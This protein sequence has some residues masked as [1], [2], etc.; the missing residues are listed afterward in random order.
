MNDLIVVD[1]AGVRGRIHAAEL[2]HGGPAVFPVAL[3]TGEHV[4]IPAS[5]LKQ[6]GANL[7][8]FP[9][10]FSDLIREQHSR[11]GDPQETIIP[12]VEEVLEVQRRHVERGVRVTKT[13]EE[14]T[15]VIDASAVQS[16]VNVKRVP[17][18]RVVDKPIPL[19]RE[20]DTIIIPV[21]DETVVC[22][23]RLVLREELHVTV[24]RHERHQPQEVTLRREKVDIQPLAEKQDPAT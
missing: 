23:K 11:D 8:Y 9:R 15:E 14:H 16:A 13:T 17:I 12:V 18:N 6:R 5:A 21:M 22:E 24:Q 1:N 4:M 2:A 19:R 7:F 20:G 3:P 10:R